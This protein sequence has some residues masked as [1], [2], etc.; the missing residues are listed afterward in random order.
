MWRKESDL[1]KSDLF[2]YLSDFLKFTLLAL[3]IFLFGSHESANPKIGNTKIEFNSSEFRQKMYSEANKA[4]NTRRDLV[5][6]LVYKFYA[7]RKYMPAWTVNFKTNTAYNKLLN[8]LKSANNYGLNPSTYSVNEL[9][10]LD[11]KMKNAYNDKDKLNIRV[12]LEETATS[13]ALLFMINIAAGIGISDTALS[14]IEL[15]KNYSAF[16]NQNIQL[17]NLEQEI[18]SIQPQSLQYK[19]LQAALVKFLIR[20]KLNDQLFSPEEIL[21]TNGLLEKILMNQGYLDN[22]RLNDTIK[23]ATAL[24]NFQRF[25]DIEQTGKPDHSTLSLLG[26][27][28]Y[29]R[30]NQIAVN[31]DRLRKDE[32]LKENYILVNIP[33]FMLYYFNSKGQKTDYTV[34]VGKKITPTPLLTSHIERIVANPH[35]TVPNSIAVNEMI[36]KIQTD[37]T[38]LSRNGFK[39]VDKDAKAIDEA[40]MDW[41]TMNSSNFKYYIRQDNSEKNALGLLKFLFPNEFSVYLHDTPSKQYFKKGLRAYS[42]GCVRVENPGK[43]AQQIIASYCS[44][45]DKELSIEKVIKAGKQKDIRLKEPLSIFIK[46]YTCTAD[47]LENIYYH[48]D[49]YS[50][51][52][53][54]IGQL[55]AKSVQD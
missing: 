39:I 23:I 26:A 12:R 19:L 10:D 22:S 42:H 14:T 27:S 41:S 49:V 3:A 32:L 52:Q 34:V 45:D 18:I 21:K 24:M 51:D 29:E 8:I 46:Y 40:E 20:E 38:Y 37:S 11:M 53:A 17:E 50:Y 9:S 44:D 55:F 47:S 1:N 35:W 43:L 28:S 25:H 31:L 54:A 48:P 13:S 30:Y 7:E 16:L 36:P 4:M 2:E 33:E 15:T 5:D 6:N